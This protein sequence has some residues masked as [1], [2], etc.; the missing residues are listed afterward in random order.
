MWKF[1][2]LLL[3]WHPHSTFENLW[4]RAVSRSAVPIDCK[5]TFLC[6]GPLIWHRRTCH[7]TFAAVRCSQAKRYFQNNAIARCDFSFRNSFWCYISHI[8]SVCQFQSVCRQMWLDASKV[9][10]NR[11]YDNL[12]QQ[13]SINQNYTEKW[14]SDKIII[15]SGFCSK[16][17]HKVITQKVDWNKEIKIIVID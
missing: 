12:C 17:N 6:I 16:I 3:N 15:K 13:Q 9:P 1:S 11:K 5:Q 4:P 2:T 8:H 7:S 14:I 10:G